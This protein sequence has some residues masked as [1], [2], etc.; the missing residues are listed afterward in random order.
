MQ[1]LPHYY[2]AAAKAGAEGEVS[3]SCSDLEPIA[4]TPPPEFGG[5]GGHWSPETL[6]VAAVADCFVLSFRAIARASNFTW[7]DLTC[8]VEGVLE[9]SDGVT[10]FTR[11]LVRATLVIAAATLETRAR[12]L[13]Q[14]A[15]ESCLIT[16]SLSGSTQLEITLVITPNE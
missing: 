9:R 5:P 7:S 15:E 10:Q 2:K 6:L 8:E 1:D 14:K 3:V 12:R 16:N 4:S 13:L 11:Y